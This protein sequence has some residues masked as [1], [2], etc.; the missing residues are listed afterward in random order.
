[1]TTIKLN[2]GGT[3]FKTTLETLMLIPY[4]N[5]GV[6]DLPKK[7][8]VNRSGMIFHHVL[9][10]IL[11]KEYCFP[12]EYKFELDFYDIK[13]DKMKFQVSNNVIFNETEKLKDKVKKIEDDLADIL[14]KVEKLEDNLSNVLSKVELLENNHDTNDDSSDDILIIVNKLDADICKVQ[15]CD[16]S[17][18]GDNF[19]GTHYKRTGLCDR[20]HCNNRTSKGEGYCHMHS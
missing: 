7:I 6:A 18:S 17:N 12:A 2:V 10:A 4:F 20:R 15:D 19:C 9:A 13:Y 16:K 11:D 1:M 14:T 3:K 5:N 8:F